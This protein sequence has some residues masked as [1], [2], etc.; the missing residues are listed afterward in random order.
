M[1]QQQNSTFIDD[2]AP[3]SLLFH[4][5]GSPIITPKN[6]HRRQNQRNANNKEPSANHLSDAKATAPKVD[7]DAPLLTGHTQNKHD[8]T[9]NE[10]DQPTKATNRRHL[11]RHRQRFESLCNANSTMKQSNEELPI[12]LSCN[13]LRYV[14]GVTKTTTCYEIIKAL[15]DDELCNGNDNGNAQFYNTENNINNNIANNKLGPKKKK[16]GDHGSNSG[17]ELRDYNDFVITERLR[18]IERSYD[19][20]MAIL[21]VWLAGS[22]VHNEAQMQER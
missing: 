21:P 4:F 3:G 9:T 13:E 12:W 5:P 1:Q 20:A 7:I 19:S 8:N 22:R 15:I 10:N 14:S 11:Y 17:A 16:Y 2:H 6:R 18:G